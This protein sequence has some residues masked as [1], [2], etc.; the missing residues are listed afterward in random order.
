VNTN[1]SPSSNVFVSALAVVAV[2]LAV[3]SLYLAGSSRNVETRMKASVGELDRRL[4]DGAQQTPDVGGRRAN[5]EARSQRNF[6]AVGGQLQTIMAKLT[7]PPPAPEK[8]QAAGAPKA[9]GAKTEAVY[10]V[11]PGETLQ[12]IAKAHGTTVDAI[13]KANPGLDARHL[14]ADQK[15]KVPT[16]APAA[17]P[18]A[19]A[20]PAAQPAA[21]P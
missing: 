12:R 17:K 5:R 20:R 19:P 1:F 4:N 2:V 3:I 14:K 7:A 13:L 11:K 10:K 18:A 6:M 15:I 8:A 9:E 16:A 21:Q